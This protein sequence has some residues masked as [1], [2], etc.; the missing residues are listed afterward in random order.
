[1]LIA[2]N[3]PQARQATDALRVVAYDQIIGYITV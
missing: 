3:E 1:M 2:E